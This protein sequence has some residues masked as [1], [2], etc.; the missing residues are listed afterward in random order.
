[1]KPL[2]N[3]RKEIDGVLMSK[4]SEAMK[5]FEAQRSKD[6]ETLDQLTEQIH[7][8]EVKITVARSLQEK[9]SKEFIPNNNILGEQAQK[10]QY[11]EKNI[12]GFQKQI[13]AIFQ[14]MTAFPHAIIELLPFLRLVEEVSKKNAKEEKGNI[15]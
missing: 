8:L 15:S 1:M 7:E 12:R 5:S 4:I 3:W 2:R 13:D 14:K 10:I 6:I 11:C 9:E